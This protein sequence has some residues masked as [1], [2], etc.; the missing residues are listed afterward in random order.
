[1]KSFVASTSDSA[2]PDKFLGYMVPS[3]G[4]VILSSKVSLLISVL[5]SA[6]PSF[7]ICGHSSNAFSGFTNLFSYQR[8]FMMKVKIF[9]TR[10]FA[11]IAGMYVPDI[12]NF[13]NSI[14]LYT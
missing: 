1:M 13:L 9:L 14:V 4:E 3:V 6:N 8:I 5:V 10:G 2:K 12:V 11:N 7:E